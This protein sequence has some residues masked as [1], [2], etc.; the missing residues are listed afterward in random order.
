[1]TARTWRLYA[2]ELFGD[3]LGGMLLLTV[4]L[5]RLRPNSVPGTILWGVG[6]F[7][8]GVAIEVAARYT[9]RGPRAERLEARTANERYFSPT[10]LMYL[11]SILAIYVVAAAVLIGVFALLE[12]HLPSIMTGR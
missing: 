2:L 1:M 5:W 4:F 6:V 9:L 12:P 7:G 11:L 3:S 8:A 10:R